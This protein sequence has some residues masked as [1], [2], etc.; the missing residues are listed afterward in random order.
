MNSH[1][2]SL[3]YDSSKLQKV[4]RLFFERDARTRLPTT[5]TLH[6]QLFSDWYIIDLFA[7]S[8]GISYH[9]LQGAAVLDSPLVV[10]L[11]NTSTTRTDESRGT[12]SSSGSSSTPSTP[13]TTYALFRRRS[14]R[15]PRLIEKA[16]ETA[17]GL[18][19]TTSL[20]VCLDHETPLSPNLMTLFTLVVENC[21]TRTLYLLALEN[22]GVRP[23]SPIILGSTEDH[24]S[25]LRLLLLNVP[26]V[27]RRVATRTHDCTAGMWR[28]L[29]MLRLIIDGGL[30]CVCVWQLRTVCFFVLCKRHRFN[31]VSGAH[32]DGG[33]G[34]GGRRQQCYGHG[35][36]P[37]LLR[38]MLLG[39]QGI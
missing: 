13:N 12:G 7:A 25:L 29:L 33:N 16:P 4:R 22:N 17:E 1:L 39:G 23:F 9:E 19:T 21:A 24:L 30:S 28:E 37:S 27:L 3:F 18:L 2:D 20:E 26:H 31:R 35:R 6:R 14:Q 10:S 15:I 11:A 8:Q 36:C 38:R 32:R 5:A 34:G